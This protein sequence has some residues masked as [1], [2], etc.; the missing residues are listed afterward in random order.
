[1]PQRLEPAKNGKYR[2]KRSGDIVTSEE[3]DRA[4]IE[5]RRIEEKILLGYCG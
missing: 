5:E 1:M 4:K 3:K 2:P